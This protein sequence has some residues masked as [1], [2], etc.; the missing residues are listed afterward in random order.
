MLSRYKASQEKV[1]R[2]F[3]A[4]KESEELMHHLSKKNIPSILGNNDF[5]QSVKNRFSL[6]EKEKEVPESSKFCTEVK[7]I[8]QVIC[9]YYG[10][11]ETHL[12]KSRRGIENETRDL[13]MYMLR[14][15][16]AERLTAIG[17]EFNLE[18]YSSV[19]SAIERIRKKMASGK[20]RKEYHEILDLL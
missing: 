12:L 4:L 8:K 7:D 20:L 15:A 11:N 2:K 17:N 6:K 1:Y 10:I 13:G 9:S 14:V 18:N 3:M 19:S 16:R 5:I